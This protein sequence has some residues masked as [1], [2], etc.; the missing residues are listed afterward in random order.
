[1]KIKIL[2]YNNDAYEFEIDETTLDHIEVEIIT[3]DELITIHYKDGGHSRTHDAARYSEDFRFQNYYDGWYE[4][5]PDEIEEWMQRIDSYE[6]LDK[7]EITV[8][9]TS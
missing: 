7:K 3:G 6:W 2:N 8:K 4:I 5:Y 9:G 1:M